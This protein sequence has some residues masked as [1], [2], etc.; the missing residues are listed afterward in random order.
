M[1]IRKL[2]RYLFCSV[3]L[4]WAF[5][6]S[7]CSKPATDIFNNETTTE[8]PI[9]SI[10]KQYLDGNLTYEWSDN[11]SHIS[12]SIYQ[13]TETPTELNG[14]YAILKKIGVNLK[15]NLGN[16]TGDKTEYRYTYYND[17]LGCP[18]LSNN[19]L[20]DEVEIID[21]CFPLPI[22]AQIGS[23]ATFTQSTTYQN[24]SK[25]TVVD[26]SKIIWRLSQRSSDTAY[27]CFD[28]IS[29][30]NG[31]SSQCF[32]IDKNGN[33]LGGYFDVSDEIR[34]QLKSFNG[35]DFK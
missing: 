25:E 19:S 15:G 27:L 32:E 31:N 35:K 7:A 8:Y 23:Q 2:N 5:G 33:I 1:V 17:I 14:E 3:I 34:S 21:E 28:S 26:T 13:L 12:F 4:C 16:E 22:S 20:D 30:K 9:A 24:D 29:I 6:L 11:H 18:L 10:Y